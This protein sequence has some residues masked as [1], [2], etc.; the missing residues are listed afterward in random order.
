ME[1]EGG[2]ARGERNYER[3]IMRQRGEERVRV[4]GNIRASRIASR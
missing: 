3:E 4:E 2:G 1:E